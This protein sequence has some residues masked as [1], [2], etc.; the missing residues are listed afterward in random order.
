MDDTISLFLSLPIIHLRNPRIMANRTNTTRKP[1]TTYTKHPIPELEWTVDWGLV[2]SY[3][4]PF[5]YVG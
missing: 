3:L 2:V 4:G 1:V 5:A